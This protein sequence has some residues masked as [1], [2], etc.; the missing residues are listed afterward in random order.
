VADTGGKAGIRVATDYSTV[1]NSQVKSPLILHVRATNFFGG[2]EKQILGHIVS[3]R[4]YR[5][6]VITFIDGPTKNELSEKCI[7][8]NIHVY[9]L[10]ARNAFD[11]LIVVKLRRAIVSLAPS[12]ICSHGYRSTILL[13]LAT[14]GMKIPI[15]AFARGFTAEN[16]KVAFFEFWER[17]TLSGLFGI[18]CIFEAQQRQLERMGVHAKKWWTIH[19]AVAVF[20]GAGDPLVEKQ[21]RKSLGILEDGALIVC[22]GR[23]SPEK[24]QKDLLQAIPMIRGSD[25][26][27]CFVICGDGP[28]RESLE[29]EA[30][31]LGISDRVRFVG[32]RRDLL[33][34]FRIMDLLVLPSYT[35]GLPNVILE[36]FSCAKPVVA[37]QVGGVPEIVENGRNGLLIPP[38]R[39]DL[40]AQA[41]E[42]CLSSNDFMESMGR[43]GRNLII[44][45]FSFEEQTRKLES[46]Y[47]EILC[48]HISN[49]H[50]PAIDRSASRQ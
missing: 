12:L 34:I 33:E 37:T 49:G 45:K 26:K 21:L 25:R 48:C 41:V 17:R 42:K 43:S 4:N 46:V 2:P 3:S 14:I 6:A 15:V 39:P 18:I 16:A 23:L 10:K 9:S 27:V 47:K 31:N 13:T 38:G 7:E 1:K 29:Q 28:C 11:P 50:D 40:L 36:A 32:F 22:A 5:H 8:A 30:A 19:N 35:E 44:S 24:G 20:E